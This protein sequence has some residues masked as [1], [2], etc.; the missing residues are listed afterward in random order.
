M[1][2]QYS[3]TFRWLVMALSLITGLK[4]FFASKLDLYS[5]EA[6]YWLASTDLSLGY[7]DLPFMTALLVKAGSSFTAG[8]AFAVRLFFLILGSSVPLLIYW[9]ARPMSGQRAALHSALYSICL[10]LGGL[11]GL[12]AVP[13]VPLVFFGLLA[14]GFFE[15]ALRT[16]R[17]VFWLAT[18]V[19]VGCGLS[20]HYRF[21]LYPLAAFLFLILF[22]AERRQ[23]RNPRFFLAVFI[24]SIGLTPIIWF[25]IGNQLSSFTF[26]FVESVTLEEDLTR[27]DFTINSIAKD[28]N[29]NL[30][31][32][33]GGLVDIKNKIFRQASQSFSED[34][35]R[36]IRYARFK[37]YSHLSDFNLDD[38]TRESIKNIGQS[39]ELAHLSADRVWMEVEKALSSPKTANFFSSLISLGL[40][41]PW[42]PQI[43]H[44]DID[45]SNSPQLKWVEIQRLNT[46]N[47][48]QYKLG[49]PKEFVEY[50]H[51]SYSLDQID[52]DTLTDD[53]LIDALEE[54][55]LHRNHKKVVE[56]L[57]LKLFDDKRDY[58]IKLKDNILSKDFSILGQAPKE[59]VMKI[60]K[61]LYIEAIKETFK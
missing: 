20:T 21:F 59:D 45:E 56:I 58:W 52:F 12:L 27:R 40:T 15:R 37:T 42:F 47:I 30:I 9:I 23:W 31:D 44:F 41:E 2:L 36:A 29:G 49:V 51:L 48:P 39:N 13:D 18:G 4:L 14:I 1:Q 34:P 17:L 50:C 43:K 35:L 6:F 57:K 54:L 11:L 19:T 55:N 22:S 25:N 53:L 61:D 38:S 28:A 10:P 60:K 16:N 32:P 24:A 7:S 5:D 33:Y 46:P 26:Y 8:S 3:P